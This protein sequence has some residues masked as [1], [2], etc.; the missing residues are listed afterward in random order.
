MHESPHYQMAPLAEAA[1]MSLPS[2]A[3][4]LS[5]SI[6][7]LNLLAPIVAMGKTK[8]GKMAVPDN[9]TQIGWYG[10]GAKPGEQG[11]AVLGAHVDNGGRV[12]G[13]FKNLKKMKVGDELSI[14]TAA[15]QRLT[16]RV[17]E[18]RVYNYRDKNTAAIFNQNS[19]AYLNLI[20]CHGTWLPREKT[21]NQRL[22][23]FTELVA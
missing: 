5:L 3:A 4:P 10:L 12:A 1:P 17:T 14:T 20:T 7:K 16:F 22:V 11:S 23:V 21:Y 2:F 18:T 8:A 9:Y 13:I 6:A 19:G 15:G